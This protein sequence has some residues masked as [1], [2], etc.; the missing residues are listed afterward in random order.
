MSNH[1]AER[2]YIA[3]ISAMFH[4]LRK[5]LR[6]ETSTDRENRKQ[7]IIDAI[8]FLDT[9][10]FDQWCELCGADP[11]DIRRSMQAEIPEVW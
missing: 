11:I 2:G 7:I 8:H 5:D 1:I 4:R 6:G 3:L 9:P 10:D